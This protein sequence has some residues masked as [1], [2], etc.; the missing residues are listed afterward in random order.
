ME[1]E[2][3]ITH[4][5]DLLRYLVPQLVKFPRHQKFVL[6]DRIQNLLTDILQQLV[7]SYFARPEI[8]KPILQQVNLDLEVLRY[9][10]RLAKDLHCLDLRRYEYVQEKINNIGAQ[11]G[12]WIKSLP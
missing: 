1:K 5:Y 7:K 12:A 10:V 3:V 9:L 11:V 6:A 4:T 2:N 8:K